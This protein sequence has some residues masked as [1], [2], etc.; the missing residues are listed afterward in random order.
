MLP[1]AKEGSGVQLPTKEELN[2]EM[3]SFKRQSVKLE[4]THNFPLAQAPPETPLQIYTPE[5][6][7]DLN[8]DE[9][10]G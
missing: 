8:A 3:A 5:V 7:F 4:P 6:G 1:T 2:K 10:F 9:S